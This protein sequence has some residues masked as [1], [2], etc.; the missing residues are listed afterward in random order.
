MVEIQRA[1]AQL[2]PQNCF[3]T[4]ADVDTLEPFILRGQ[5]RISRR[6]FDYQSRKL[7]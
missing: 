7:N 1:L 3:E 2:A 6:E 4:G 5:P